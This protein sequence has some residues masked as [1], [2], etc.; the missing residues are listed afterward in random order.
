MAEITLQ[1][2]TIHTAGELPAP[3]SAAPDFVL[4]KT[5]LSDVSLKNFAGKRVVLNIFPSVDTSVCAISVRKFNEAVQKL[6]NAVVLGVSA[7][8]PFAHDRF[9]KAEGIEDLIS[10]SALRD[11]TF[12]DDYG[13]RIADGPLSGLLSRAV[14]VIDAEGQVLH[15]EQVPEITQEPNY[16]AAL[17]ALR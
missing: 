8:L 2:N 13:V 15:R 12:G 11:R 16:E 14:V 6:D 9:N 7:D 10:L 3:G 17:A 1:G 5:D 4:T